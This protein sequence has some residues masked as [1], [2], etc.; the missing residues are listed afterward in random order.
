[1]KAEIQILNYNGARLLEQCMP[2]IMAAARRSSHDCKIV[3]VDNRSTDESGEVVEKHFPGAEFR[4]MEEN[5]V[6]CSL[7]ESARDSDADILIFLNNDLKVEEDFIDPLLSVFEDKKDAFL[8]V[9]CCYS[10]DGAKM[11]V[12]RTVPVFAW[13]LLKG[14]PDPDGE[15]ISDVVYTLQG[16]F[17]AFHR[18]KFLELG[19]YDDI[20]LPGI[21]EDTDVCY[22][23]WRKGY[24]CYYQPLSR[25]YHMGRASFSK[26]FGLK[27]L[28]SLSH[29]NT[30][31]FAWKHIRSPLTMARHLLFI[32]P[33]ML[34][35][36]VTGKIEILWGF[37][38]ALGK[39]QRV[40]ERR[41]SE[42]EKN[43]KYGFD[44]VLGLFSGK[45]WSDFY[46]ETSDKKGYEH[47]LSVHSEFLEEI[48][49]AAPSRVL[50]VGSGSGTMASFLSS[51]IDE[52][53][54]VDND[55]RVLER[56]RENNR[57]FNGSAEFL[58]SD[59]FAL[60]FGRDRFDLCFSQG[61]FEH[62]SDDDI[63]ALVREQ[64]RVAREA[65]FSV[66]TVF[67][68]NR[69]FGNE[70]LLSMRRWRRILKD[71]NLIEDKYYFYLRRKKNF[72]LRL[73]MMY[74][75]RIGR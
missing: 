9:P 66:P 60:P 29:R 47:N 35:S 37:L 30:Y 73:P 54:S 36:I 20:Y 26:A 41:R 6:L 34:Y 27:K 38:R 1:M 7:N 74:M 44:E 14:V 33:R 5:R 62:F 17:G 51:R 63:Q 3:V 12:S 61:F 65:I 50:E 8:S 52:V 42:K 2:S 32:P 64:L 23:A 58:K 16:G 49:K 53:V 68:R 45:R 13:G 71:F 21:I 40:R 48:L 10:F 75:A 56:A 59:A 24:A 4:V 69:D 67:Y 28:L 46:N 19:G 72:L 55:R 43:Y 70:R 25:V 15:D 18:G 39:I 11:E 22:R 31:I 57:K